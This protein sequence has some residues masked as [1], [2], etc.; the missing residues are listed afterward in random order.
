MYKETI[1]TKDKSLDFEVNDSVESLFIQDFELEIN[2]LDS[3]NIYSEST[4]VLC[5]FGS[6]VIG[7]YFKSALYCYLYDTRNEL[8]N[9]PINLLILIQAITQ[10]ILYFLV[11]SFYV[12]GLI[13]NITYSESVGEFW[14]N[15]PWY[16][17][18]VASAYRSINSLGMAIFRLLLIKCNFWV[19]DKIGMKKMFGATLTLV[20]IITTLVVTGF[21][22]GN[23]PGT[24]RQVI[25]NFCTGES[26]KFREIEHQYSLLTGAIVPESELM[27]FLA[28]ALVTL[29]VLIELFCYVTFF[30]HLYKNDSGLLAKKLLPADEI[31]RRYRKNAITFFGQ[32]YG[33]VSGMMLYLGVLLTF[34]EGSDVTLRLWIILWQAIEFGIVSVVEVMTSECLPNYLPHKYI[35]KGQ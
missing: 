34:Q 26:L 6:L 7:G 35:W 19:K 31:K 14:C 9:R 15:V 32:F 1:K 17:Q 33:F 18:V 23:G 25:W 4:L 27:A 30:A 29:G 8:G 28:V 13:F 16:A 24:R 2:A 11:V 21:S 5:L 20:I 12:T 22:M 3:L 10:H